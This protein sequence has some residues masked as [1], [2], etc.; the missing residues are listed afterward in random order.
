MLTL[1]GSG[2][3][4]AFLFPIIADLVRT[5]ASDGRQVSSGQGY[6]RSYKVFPSALVLAPTRE[7]AVQIQKE[8]RKVHQSFSLN[9]LS[10]LLTDLISRA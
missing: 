4:A 6:R 2:K 7:L 5:N 9:S 10:S 8:A 1:K 3:T